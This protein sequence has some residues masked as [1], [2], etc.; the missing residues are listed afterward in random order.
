MGCEGRVGV[1]FFVFFV[2]LVRVVN[3]CVQW[4]AEKLLFIFVF[5][6][7]ITLTSSQTYAIMVVLEWWI[8]GITMKQLALHL[9]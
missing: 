3:I 2:F 6:G 5:V 1:R 8:V 4:Y 9:E 7:I